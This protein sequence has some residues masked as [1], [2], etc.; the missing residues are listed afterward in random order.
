MFCICTDILG[1]LYRLSS[2]SLLTPD[3]VL[4]SIFIEMCQDA[5]GYMDLIEPEVN[6][7]R[8]GSKSKEMSDIMRRNFEVE[9][10]VWDG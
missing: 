3:W 10:Q 5:K 7:I 9:L 8:I 1:F 2:H 4:V 6:Q